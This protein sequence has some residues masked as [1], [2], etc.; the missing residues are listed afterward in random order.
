MLQSALRGHLVREL[1]LKDLLKDA[2]NKVSPTHSKHFLLDSQP[3][4]ECC[5][6]D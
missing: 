6:A 2:Q 1:Q 5:T 4:N 3:A